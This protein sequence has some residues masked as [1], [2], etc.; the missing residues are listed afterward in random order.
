MLLYEQVLGEPLGTTG[1]FARAKRPR[2]LP[3]VLTREGV[4]RLLDAL[5]GTSRLTAEL[6]YAGVVCA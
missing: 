1:D 3:V 4:K 5:S 2:R 6:S